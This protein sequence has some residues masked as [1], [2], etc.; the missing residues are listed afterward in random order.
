MSETQKE[1]VITIPATECQVIN[2]LRA[3]PD[4]FIRNDALLTELSIPHESG[5]AI[6]LME[7]QVHLFRQQRDLLQRELAELIEIARQNDRF[8]EKSKRLLVHLLEAQSL[9]EVLIMLD[10]SIRGDF[11]VPFCS[12]VLLGEKRDYAASNVTM[13]SHQRARQDL[14]S[15]LDSHR[16]VCGQFKPP[17]M[18]CLFP[19]AADKVKSAAVIPLGADDHLGMLSVGSDDEHYFTSSMGSLFLSYISDTLS[20]LLPPLLARERCSNSIEVVAK[21]LE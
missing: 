14:G 4:F 10:E 5:R 2:Y 8:F 6:S 11:G 19:L 7:R 18:R 16:A 13:I 1:P 21:L 12:L 15:L 9:D 20:R 3:H 17:Q